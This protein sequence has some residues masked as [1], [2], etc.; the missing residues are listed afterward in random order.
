MYFQFISEVR[1]FPRWPS[2]LS[3]S[4]APLLIASAVTVNA[5]P[6]ALTHSTFI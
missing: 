6:S 2:A 4:T 3:K 5:A 1:N